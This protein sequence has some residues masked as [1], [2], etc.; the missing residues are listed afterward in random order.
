M[1][2]ES[3]QADLRSYMAQWSKG[4][5][6]SDIVLTCVVLHN[7]LRTHQAGLNRTPAPAALKNEQ[8]LYV[9]EENCINPPVLWLMV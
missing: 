8:V 2:L 6:M 9:P 3:W 5:R 7:I 1:C 4:Q